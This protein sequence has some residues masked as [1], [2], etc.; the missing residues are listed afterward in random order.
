[1]NL[2]R[3]HIIIHRIPV[4]LFIW[5]FVNSNSFAR[6]DTLKVNSSPVPKNFYKT[7]SVFSFRSQKGYFPSLIY[8]VGEQ[9]LAPFHFTPKQWLY[10]AATVGSTLA[11]IQFDGDL[12]EWFR[13]KKQE[14][15]W[16]NGFSP[17]ITELGGNYGYY[18][19]GAI[20]ITYAVFNNKKGVETSLL[21]TQALITSGIWVQLIKRGT[22]RERPNASYSNSR[23]EGGYWY[24][25]MAQYDQ[26]LAIQKPGSSFDAFVSGH[27]A[28]A[29][30]IAT[31]FASRY[32]QNVI[33]PILCYST[34]TLVGLSR[35]TEHQH[36]ASDILGGAFL[37]YFCGKQVVSHFNKTHQNVSVSTSAKSKTKVE[38]SLTQNGNQVGFSLK[39]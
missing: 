20:G 5:L 13:T 27:T 4:I 14:Y 22:G 16:V 19:L 9:A 28:T 10:T 21:A 1:M 36:W 33:V 6:I 2:S 30:S 8:N 38:F 7:D 34:A 26:D 3:F 15:K 11:L 37:G 39:W 31:V 17:V 25:P 12:D 32:N 24:G 29:F 18:A 35:L 23:K